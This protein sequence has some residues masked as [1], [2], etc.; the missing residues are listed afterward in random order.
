MLAVLA[1]AL[2]FAEY[3]DLAA[4]AR[5]EIPIVATGAA[6]AAACV[7][8]A[9]DEL[10]L[11]IVLLAALV[12]VGVL[13][14]VRGQPGPEVL[15][16]AAA[17][18]LPLIYIG[19]PLGSLGGVRVIGGRD[20][21]LL[22][23]ATIV[24]SD[25]AQYY[26][27]RAF[28]RRRLAP[29]ISPSKTVEGA[30][31]GLIF[32]TAAM[33]VGGCWVL[34]RRQS[35][36]DPGA[37]VGR[38]RRP[39]HGRRSLRVAAEAQRRREGFVDAHPRSRRRPRSHRQLAVRR[40]GVLP[41]HPIPAGIMK[42]VAI[43]GSTGSIGQSALAVVAA[44]PDRLRVVALAAGEN[45]SRFVEQVAALRAGHDR[46]G[47]RTRRWPTCR[48]ELRAHARHAPIAAAACGPKA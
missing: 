22:L 24:V 6:V 47:H 17:A 33:T 4:A 29:A 41:V 28:G 48:P 20:A 2:A 44:H 40:A 34:P 43:L 42:R 35:P 13:A 25:S 19:V 10:P 27:G 16:D 1:A 18:I 14:V 3:A 39:R 36:A 45:V 26:T 30:L 38:C 12:W 46:D 37:D 15:R 8:V 7:A 21:T 23:I 9:G 5:R 31:G 32:G 11:E